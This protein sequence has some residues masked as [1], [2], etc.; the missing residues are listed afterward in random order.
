MHVPWSGHNKADVERQYVHWK[1]GVMMDL[2]DFPPLLHNL[3]DAGLQL[4]VNKRTLDMDRMRRFLL[5]LETQYE[6]EEPVYVDQYVN[7]N[8]KADNIYALP[9]KKSP[10]SKK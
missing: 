4:D 10:T 7:N 1:R 8:N 5:R 3:L 6:R 2:Y 9:I